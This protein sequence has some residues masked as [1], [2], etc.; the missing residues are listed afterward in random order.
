MIRPKNLE[1]GRWKKNERRKPRSRPKFTFDI[2][3]DK[4][5]DGKAG[6]RGHENW[7]IQFSKL[8]YPVS[9]DQ[10]STSTTANSSDN[11]SRTPPRQNSEVW[12]CRQQ[13]HHP[14]SH[15]LIGPPMPG[16]WG[17]PL[18]MYPPCPLWAGWYGPWTPPPIHFHP[19]W[20]GP[21]Q[22]FGY[23]GYYTGDDR[24]GHVGHQ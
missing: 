14:A 24:Y 7:T 15:F 8:D 20:S 21:T 5:R 12:N 16:P 10:V 3:M 13:E 2:L 11:Q 18:M 23:G 22:D 9:L 1:I 4:Y 19:R 17:P 6:F